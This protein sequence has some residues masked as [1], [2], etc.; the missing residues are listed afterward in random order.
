MT[1]S[2][3]DTTT[4]GTVTGLGIAGPNTNLLGNLGTGLGQ[5]TGSK[6]T[7]APPPKLPVPVSLDRWPASPPSRT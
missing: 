3:D 7:T 1:T 5:L 4:K 2:S 6:Q